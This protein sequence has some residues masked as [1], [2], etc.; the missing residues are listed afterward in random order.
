MQ[1]AAV[2]PALPGPAYGSNPD[3]DRPYAVAR[4]KKVLAGAPGTTCA[5]AG[6]GATLLP[7]QS[8]ADIAAAAERLERVL[9]QCDALGPVADWI[10]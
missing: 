5:D 3:I 1:V 9:A 7:W 8:G 6:G 10:R 4:V 2:R